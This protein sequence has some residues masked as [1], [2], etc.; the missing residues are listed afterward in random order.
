VQPSLKG[1]SSNISSWYKF[2]ERRAWPK[3]YQIIK[4]LM[5][6]RSHLFTTSLD[7]ELIMRVPRSDVHSP[8]SV[9]FIESVI[10]GSNHGPSLT[11]HN[12]KLGLGCIA[13]PLSSHADPVLGETHNREAHQITVFAD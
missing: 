2:V 11:V 1:R 13:N 10:V 7:V 9:K 6:V 12:R 8:G 4:D 5:G 3:D